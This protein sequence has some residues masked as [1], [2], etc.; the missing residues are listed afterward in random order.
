MPK[1]RNAKYKGVGYMVPEYEERL[2]QWELIDDATA[3]PS[4][5][6]EKA[7]L[8]LPWPVPE[9]IDQSKE[10]AARYDTYLFRAVFYGVSKRTLSGYVGQVFTTDPIFSYPETDEALGNLSADVDG[11]GIT[12]DQQA[13]KAVAEVISKG[14]SALFVDFPTT[15]G[16]RPTLKEEAENGLRPVIVRYAAEQVINWRSKA[17]GSENRLSLVMIVE[18]HAEDDDGYEEATAE[19]WKELRLTEENVYLV[20]HHRWDEEKGEFYQDGEDVIPTDANGKPFDYIPFTFIGSTN[21]DSVPDQPPMVDLC[22]LNMA[23]YRNSADNEEMLFIMG[24][25]TPYVSGLSEDWAK[26]IMG[27]NIQLGSRKLLVLP[28]GGNAGVIEISANADVLGKEMAHKEDQM[29]KLGAKLVESGGVQRTATDAVIQEASESS[30]LASAANNVSSAYTTA[31]GYIQAFRGI[32]F[33][34]G[35]LYYELSSDFDIHRLTPQ[36]QQQM[37]ANWMSGAITDSELR[38]QFLKAG[39]ATEDF[40]TWKTVQDANALNTGLASAAGVEDEPEE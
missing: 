26:E 28:E 14:R 40:D 29:V 21:N 1:D 30:V 6:K 13:Q 4:Q 34:P 27:E 24:Q 25:P 35:E 5:V 32:E 15:A 3:G 9:A 18:Q 7:E 39:I 23:H 38:D 16:E 2:P 19:R 12:L 20:R 36:G 8:Y 17:V 22:D 10:N 11:A 31:L 37:V 33:D